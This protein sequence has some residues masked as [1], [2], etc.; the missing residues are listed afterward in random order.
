M[1]V[2]QDLSAESPFPGALR[3]WLLVMVLVVAYA[4]SFVDRQILSLL[5]GG[6]KAD[7]RISDTQIGLL[8]GPAFGLFYALLGM[9]LGWLADKTDRL[10]L[11][12][13]GMLLWTVMTIVCGFADSF[14]MLFVA[15]MGVGIGE[16]A[17]VPAAVS[18]IADSFAP[19]R[20]ALPLSIFTAGIS[21]G[22][23]L[24]LVMSGA[25]IAYGNSGAAAHLPWIGSILARRAPWQIVLMLAGLGG[26]PLG[27]LIACLPGP[28]RRAVP[29]EQAGNGVTL[30][31]WVSQEKAIFLPLLAGSSLLYLFTNAFAAWMP[32]LFVR[33]FGWTPATVGVRLG[34]V[35]L[36]CALAGNLSSGGL[37]SRL[38][39]RG[40]ANA[41]LI[42]MAIGAG[43]LVPAAIFGP[44]IPGAALAQIAVAIIYFAMALC[45]GV[46]T[47]SFV[48]V[49]P[50]PIRGQMIALYLLLGNLIGLV[51]GP[52][53]VGYILD[54]ILADPSRVGQGLSIV[55]VVSVAPGFWLIRRPLAAHAARAADMAA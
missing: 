6:L 52:P 4:L 25:L 19:D 13:A 20:R 33:G 24:S 43:L 40:R 18:L 50:G 29:V 49:T 42:T 10:R 34:L 36:G 26:V 3:G 46:A 11:I 38:L 9:P 12:G 15:R 48:A 16:A 32:T 8:Q 55:A 2:A 51:L 31:R 17:L 14:P 37:A 45:F 35:I 44:L 53:S 23:G 28:G 7:L 27:L 22:V 5:V 41:S 54:H 47:A 30:A 21:V 1:D 39:R